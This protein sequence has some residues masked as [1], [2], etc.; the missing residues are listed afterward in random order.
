[1]PYSSQRGMYVVPM[2]WVVRG[3][4]HKWVW[5]VEI[6]WNFVLKH[7]LKLRFVLKKKL[8]PKYKGRIMWICIDF[9]LQRVVNVIIKKKKSCC[10]V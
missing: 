4:D 1:M 6:G 10:L 5:P 9:Y 3:G 8:H 7:K 2:S